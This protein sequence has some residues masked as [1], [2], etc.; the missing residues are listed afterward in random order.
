M[1]AL[2][3]IGDEINTLRRYP[4]KPPDV[5]EIIVEMFNLRAGLLARVF[6]NSCSPFHDLFASLEPL[7]IFYNLQTLL[8]KH[9][10]K[11]KQRTKHC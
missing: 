4:G 2:T 11:K 5:S 10:A 9:M 1:A 7:L 3:T 8:P 6:Y